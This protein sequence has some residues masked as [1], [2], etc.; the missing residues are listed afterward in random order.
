MASWLRKYN[1]SSDLP[2]FLSNVPKFPEKLNAYY[3]HIKNG[4]CKWLAC[5][6]LCRRDACDAC[7]S[8]VI[9]VYEL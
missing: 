9:E 7:K 6:G 2:F 1:E 5:M 8:I 3:L 4:K